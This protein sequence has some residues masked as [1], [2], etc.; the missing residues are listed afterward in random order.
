MVRVE[1]LVAEVDESDPGFSLLAS[2]IAVV[3]NLEEAAMVI[4]SLALSRKA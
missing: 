1:Y 3:T 4:T 2:D